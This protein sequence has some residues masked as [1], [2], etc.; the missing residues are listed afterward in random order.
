MKFTGLSQGGCHREDQPVSGT[1]FAAVQI[2][3]LASDHRTTFGLAEAQSFQTA[4]RGNNIPG[5][6]IECHTICL[7]RQCLRNEPP[8]GQISGLR[9]VDGTAEF[10]V[11]NGYVHKLSFLQRNIFCVLDHVLVCRTDDLAAGD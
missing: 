10:F 3:D 4:D 9:D 11:R 2:T 7:T 6:I 5:D 1:A 8:V